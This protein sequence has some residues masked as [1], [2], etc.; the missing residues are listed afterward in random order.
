MSSRG[1]QDSIDDFSD[2]DEGRWRLGKRTKLALLIAGVAAVVVVGLAIGRAV[3]V[4]DTPTTSPSTGSSATSAPSGVQPAELLND[5]AMLNAKDAKRVSSDRTWKVASTQRGTTADSAKPACLGEP[6]EGQPVS[7]LTM[8]RLLSANGKDQLGR[9]APGRR[10]H[11]PGRGGAGV[12]SSRE[13]TRW[14][15]RDG[16]VHSIRMERH[17][18]GR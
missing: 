16:R 18:P 5:D 14:L 8:Q 1:W 15:R 10:L 11:Y 12:R 7:A 17:G 3:L 6:A 13:D 2:I 4:G 9:P